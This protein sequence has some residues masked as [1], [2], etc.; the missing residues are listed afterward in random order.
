[1]DNLVNLS[2]FK[3]QK[4]GD[5]LITEMV[6]EIGDN[7]VVTTQIAVPKTLV[8]NYVRKV[9][10]ATQDDIAIKHGEY[11]IAESLV[12]WTN[13]NLLNVDNLPANIMTG[14]VTPPQAQQQA[15]EIQPAQTAEDVPAQ[16]TQQVQTQQVQ[17]VQ[18]PAQQTQQVQSTQG[19]GEI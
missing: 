8:K 11:Q 5:K 10:D 2:N 6:Q 4:I 18:E 13:T 7:Y 9:K 19:Q 16:Q 3:K 17:P 14:Q 1:M 12:N 15:Q